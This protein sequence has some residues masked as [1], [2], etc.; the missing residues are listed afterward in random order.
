M[1][2][3]TNRKPADELADIREGLRTLKDRE[4]VLRGQMIAGEVSL[5]G[6][7]FEV[8]VSKS[9]TEKVDTGKMKRELGLAALRPFLITAESTFVKLRKAR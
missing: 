6:D 8:V 5:I 2:Q 7:E 9:K 3:K 4:A 1:A